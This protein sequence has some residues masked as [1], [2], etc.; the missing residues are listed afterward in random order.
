M[1]FLCYFAQGVHEYTMN[2]ARMTEGEVLVEG[3]NRRS[4]QA[5][6]VRYFK[7]FL[8]GVMSVSAMAQPLLDNA[9][10]GALVITQ[11]AWHTQ[12]NQY[13]ANPASLM[14]VLT[15]T[16]ATQVLGADFRF[17]TQIS[18]AAN[19]LKKGRLMT[20]LT[21]S[22]QGDP[23]FKQKDLHAL[24][25]GL[26]KQGV[27]KLTR[28]QIDASRYQGHAWGLGQVWND[29]GICFAAPTGAAIINRNCVFGNLKAGKL[30]Q[31]AR[32]YMTPNSPLSID[33]QVLT[34]APE[35][36]KNCHVLLTIL[37]ANEYRLTGC[38]A[39]DSQRLPLGFSGNDAN[40]F[41]EHILTQE[42]A[43]L[44]F[45]KAVEI[46][47]LAPTNGSKTKREVADS[48]VNIAHYSE[49]LTALVTRMLQ[50]SDNLIADSLFK[51][52]GYQY[53]LNNNEKDA[54]QDAYKAGE[55]AVKALL[56]SHQ[57]ETQSLVIRD[58]SGLS[59][60]NLIYAKTLYQV[61]ELWLTQPQYAWLIKSL[62]V[63]AESGTL[64]NRES[65]KDQTLKGRILAKSGS[66][67]GV[68]N[69]AGFVQVEDEKKGL[70]L[71]PF[72]FIVNQFTK[73]KAE[74][75]ARFSDEEQALFNLEADFLKS[76]LGLSHS[77]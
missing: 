75:P 5:C 58:G 54:F 4:V 50:K 57:L 52:S 72:V 21:L 13:L 37:G 20:P 71:R 46:Q 8:L 35:K 16:L 22:L 23:S 47:F 26:R 74:K 64:K 45:G 15:A 49:P 40:A 32:F 42:L 10:E 28:V 59:R 55:I 9:P 53:G 34:L 11:S 43:L 7:L 31:L 70:K 39:Q 14:K 36:A 19:D 77:S 48:Q 27:T 1:G 3:F 73:S 60:E 69:L 66:M 18:Y 41:F 51:A 56:N 24:L 68:A 17:Q 6:L 2:F 29:H 67:Q 12:N 33:N 25:L 63:A 65:L 38:I 30:G 76:G 62:P 61:L 44:G